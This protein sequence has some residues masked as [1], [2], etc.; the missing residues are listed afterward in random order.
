MSY[1]SFEIWAIILLIGFGTLV[2][3]YSFLGLIGSRSLPEW[4]LRHLRYTPVAVIPG[5]MAPLVFF[6]PVTEGESDPGRLAVAAATLLAGVL[7]RSPLW[8]IAAGVAVLTALALM[9]V[10]VVPD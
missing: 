7:T 3:R 4:V 2:L 1:S 8:A 9:G 5:L 6:P 10:L